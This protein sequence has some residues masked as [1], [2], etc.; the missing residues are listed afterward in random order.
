MKAPG[1][2]ML[3]LGVVERSLSHKKLSPKMGGANGQG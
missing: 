2:K 1:S 3:I